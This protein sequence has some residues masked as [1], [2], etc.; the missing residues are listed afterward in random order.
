[1]KIKDDNLNKVGKPKVFSIENFGDV[2]LWLTLNPLR[3]E[4]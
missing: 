1:M 4:N 3:K 2:D